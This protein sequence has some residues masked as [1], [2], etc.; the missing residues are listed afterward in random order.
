MIKVSEQKDIKLWLQVWRT[1]DWAF[2]IFFGVATAMLLTVMVAFII[3]T[4]PIYQVAYYLAT[5]PAMV[6]F[7]FQ[8][9]IA[10]MGGGLFL[11]LASLAA[12]F[13]AWRYFC[14]RPRMITHQDLDLQLTSIKHDTNEIR[15]REMQ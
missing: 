6:G 4:D 8:M 14:V 2:N 1:W 5:S 9:R 15:L 12:V 7:P 13:E 3:A 11:V 10:I